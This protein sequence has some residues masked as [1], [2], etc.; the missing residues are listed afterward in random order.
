MKRKYELEDNRYLCLN[1]I[2]I[3]LLPS[4]DTDGKSKKEKMEEYAIFF[5]QFLSELYQLGGASLAYEIL[6][7]TE[8]VQN[9][10]IQSKIHI[11]FILRMIGENDVEEVLNY[12]SNNICDSLCNM[13][14]FNRIIQPNDRKFAKLLDCVDDSTMF[15]ITK[16]EKCS[17]NSRS[18]YPYY[19][20]EVIA[21]ENYDDFSGIVAFMSQS[22]NCCLSFQLIPTKFSEQEKYILTEMSNELEQINTGIMQQGQLLKDP[23]AEEPAKVY[24][25]YNTYQDSPLFQYNM[26]VIGERRSC[27]NLATKLMS[28]L[29]NGTKLINHSEYMCI[30]LSKEKFDFSTRFPNYIWNVNSK[31]LYE[32][33]NQKIRQL[34]PISNIM[35]RM[36]YIV[37]LEEAISFFRL[38]LYIDGMMALQTSQTEQTMDRF[39]DAVVAKENIALGTIYGGGGNQITIGCSETAFTKHALIVGTPG[40]GKTTFSIHLLLQFAKRGIPFLAIEPTKTEYRA[41]IDAVENLQIFT[42]G[43]SSVSPFIINPFIP[44]KGISIE[45]YIPSL[46]SAFKA[47]FSMPSPLDMFFLKAIRNCY[48]SYGWKDYSQYGDSD[49]TVFG[50]YEFILVFKKLIQETNYSKEVRGNLESAGLLRLMNLIEQ[51]SN[52]YDSI[53]TIPLE[54]ILSRP[55][56]L[57]LNAIDNTEQKSLIMALL[58]I[59]ICVYTKKNHIGDGKLKNVILIDEAHVLLGGGGNV[60]QNENGFSTIKAL[61]DM[62]AEIRSYGTGIIIADQSPTKVSREI[63]ANTDI[64]VSFRLVQSAEKV[65][66]ADSSNM[67]EYAQ[68]HLATLK[69][70]EAYVYYSQLERAQFIITEDIRE[71]ENIRLSVSDQEI[72]SRSTYWQKNMELLK[73]YAECK[74][75]RA[76]KNGCNF[77]IRAN[78]EYIA[79]IVLESHK[80]EIGN[81]QDVKKI[82]FYMPQLASPQFVNYCGEEK[83][84]IQVCARIKLLRKVLMEFPYVLSD[85][86]KKKILYYFTT[87]GDIENG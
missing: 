53:H 30:D 17:V 65:L 42:P 71:K 67:D 48:I 46:A 31:L 84:Q 64:K 12:I 9:Q 40:S 72:C 54:D 77:K 7:M 36:P 23:S 2:E 59:N 75:C 58:L 29:Q 8:N 86:D 87:E 66:M 6:W 57:E 70:G 14:F 5:R 79:N 4:L 80:R 32:Y 76:C 16:K 74:G 44:P 13:K 24:R 27:A 21:S 82:V 55:T 33:R 78:A 63:I 28:L 60:G 1:I 62:I 45:E 35:F 38:P 56:V 18:P 26:L 69:P 25:Y 19:Y 43:N 34:I 85:Q 39:S 3:E 50:L 37:T 81:A 10:L 83:E 20:G 22:T 51:N 15:C 41:M 68:M 47:A 49:V 52:I 73:P 61:Q 11:Y